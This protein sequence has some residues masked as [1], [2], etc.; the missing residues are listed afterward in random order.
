MET[1]FPAFKFRDE[2]DDG[3]YFW[4]PVLHGK[5]SQPTRASIGLRAGTVLESGFGE[6]DAQ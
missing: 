4:I 2:S 6:N 3:V 5:F 1:N